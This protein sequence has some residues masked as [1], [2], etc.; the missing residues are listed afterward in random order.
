MA[1][2]TKNPIFTARKD[3]W[4]LYDNLFGGTKT[5][6]EAGIAYLPKEIKESED[7]YLSRLKRTVLF[8]GFKRSLRT[9]SSRPFIQ[10]VQT[11]DAD[12]QEEMWIE[13][14][15]RC[16]TDLNQFAKLMLTQALKKNYCVVLVDHPT[17]DEEMDH[18]TQI[19][20][21]IR[22]YPVII[23]NEALIDF[24]VEQDESSD[25]LSELRFFE[26]YEEQE[27][28]D[29]WTK[30]MKKQ[31]K[32]WYP[33][34]IQ[35]YRSAKDSA[36]QN[37]GSNI[38]VADW[39][40]YEE[41]PNTLGEIPAVILYQDKLGVFDSDNN[42]NDLAWLNVNHWQSSSDQQ[43]ILHIARVPILHYRG[44]NKAN[45]IEV[46][47]NT[48]I[49]STA[50][51]SVLEYV[52]HSGAAVGAGNT[53]IMA[54]EDRMAVMGADMLVKRTA[55]K[56][57]TEKLLNEEAETSELGQMVIA[58]EQKIEEIFRLMKAWQGAQTRIKISIF[59]DFAINIDN[60][61][62]PILL[63]SRIN[64]EITQETYLNELKRRGVLDDTIDADEEAL[65]TSLDD[66]DDF[67][68]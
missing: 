13:N 24:G 42:L 11:E 41:Y 9:L 43:N 40:L 36:A 12:D 34:K 26:M 52:E 46:G 62:L 30:V 22:G 60:A 61:D 45:K 44:W 65:K 29:E 1:I 48:M 20:R 32:V 33:D 3:E 51:D 6:R 16:G 54:I 23:A 53:E 59:K 15:D 63:N 4:E 47:P 27:E 7:A 58:L 21:D 64:N 57:A 50:S 28:G 39:T 55:S 14:I 17:V 68:E 56:T 37:Q 67:A 31:I 66:Q 49:K 35:V 19:D 2:D 10:P 38:P 25:R 18:R 5:M 8:N